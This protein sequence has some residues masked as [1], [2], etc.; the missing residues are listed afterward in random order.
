NKHV[1]SFSREA[2]AGL[3]AD[4]MVQSV[5]ASD[6]SEEQLLGLS[7]GELRGLLYS[8]NIIWAPDGDQAFDDGSC[9]VQFDNPGSVRIIGFKFD[10]SFHHI[11]NTLRDISLDA[12]KFY[13]ILEEWLAEFEAEWAAAAKVRDS[14]E[15]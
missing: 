15:Q 7:R 13:G 14:S 10:A 6:E 8:N 3:I 12:D 4:A 5:Y 1:A 11:P 9:V 2:D